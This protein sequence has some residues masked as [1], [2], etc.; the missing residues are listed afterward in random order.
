[1]QQIVNLLAIAEI[2][3]DAVCLYTNEEL[4]V[5]SIEKGRSIIRKRM[6]INSQSDPMMAAINAYIE[7]KDLN[8]QNSLIQKLL[9]SEP[10]RTTEK[11]SRLLS[12]KKAN[13]SK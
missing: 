5:S 7:N 6:T 11:V 13:K 1:M 2:V 12:D 9:W 10:L 8:R 4:W 3:E